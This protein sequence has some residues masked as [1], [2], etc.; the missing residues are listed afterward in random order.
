[1]PKRQ[2]SAK[3]ILQDVR[4]GMDDSALPSESLSIPSVMT[5]NKRESCRKG[6]CH[7]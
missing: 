5:Y 4:A 2:L 6:R 7:A 1:M 3:E